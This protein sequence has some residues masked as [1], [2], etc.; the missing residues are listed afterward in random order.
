MTGS[1]KV[2]KAY[3]EVIDFIAAGTD[4]G[5]LIAFHPS[6]EAK[7]RVADLIEREKTTGISP[8][9]KAELDH[10]MQLEHILRMLKTKAR[11]YVQTGIRRQRG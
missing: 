10:Y 8:D 3:E 9:E 6:A 7:D 2:A 11:E 5:R 1:P 4:P